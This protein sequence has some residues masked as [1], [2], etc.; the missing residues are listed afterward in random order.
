MAEALQPKGEYFQLDTYISGRAANILLTLNA[1]QPESATEHLRRAIAV[2]KLICDA[3]AA[4]GQVYA[5]KP[6]EVVLLEPCREEPILDDSA[7]RLTV[8]VNQQAA[9]FLRG[10]ELVEG[11]QV[12]QTIDNAISD[13]GAFMQHS[14]EGAEF[15]LQEADGTEYEI[16]ILNPL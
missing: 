4:N 7:I 2:H 12:A 11:R 10:I 9:E 15:R 14:L 8:L 1:M 5:I 6:T 3:C 13:Y 16:A